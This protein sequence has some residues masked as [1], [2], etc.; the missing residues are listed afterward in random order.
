M[1]DPNETYIEW[2]RYVD[3]AFR[4]ELKKRREAGIYVSHEDEQDMHQAVV[5]KVLKYI[6]RHDPAKSSLKTFLY[7]IVKTQLKWEIIRIY[8]MG[9]RRS[10]ESWYRSFER[11]DARWDAPAERTVDDILDGMDDQMRKAV[12]LLLDGTSHEQVRH[13]LGMTN[14]EWVAML[15]EIREYLTE[16][17]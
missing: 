9:G 7:M 5:L 12:E 2:S 14:D 16:C 10:K 4:I 17:P 8:G 15:D 1:I 3:T 11:L 6:P 13:Q